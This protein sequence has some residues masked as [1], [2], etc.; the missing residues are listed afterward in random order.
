MLQT[1]VY[2]TR[3]IQSPRFSQVLFT[4][5]SSLLWRYGCYFF[6][7]WRQRMDVKNL[8]VYL[9]FE[10]ALNEIYLPFKYQALY[11]KSR[12]FQIIS[13]PQASRTF[14]IILQ[15]V[16]DFRAREFSKSHIVKLLI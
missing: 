6:F 16:T 3:I 11:L 4:L 9:K 15:D 8:R 12:A 7:N 13:N 10:L 5:N 2:R 1:L 14:R